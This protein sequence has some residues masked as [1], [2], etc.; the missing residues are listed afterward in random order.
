MKT[1]QLFSTF[2]LV[3]LTISVA[4]AKKSAGLVEKRR[5]IVKI[6]DV[7]ARDQLSVD[8]QYGQVKI[9]LWDRKEIRVDITITANAPTDQRAADYLSAIAIDEKREGHM[10]LLRTTI[11]R[12]S[13][14]SNS[15]NSWR[16]KPGE[17]NFIQI[18]YVVNMPKGNALIVRNKFGNTDIPTF[19]APLTV[20]SRYG[21]FSADDLENV[22]NS[23]EVLYGNAKIGRM[24]GGKLEVRYSNLDLDRV[25]TLSLINKFGKLTIGEVGSLDADIDYSGAIIGSIKESCRVKLSYSGGFQVDQLPRSAENVDIQ[26]AY[27]SVTLPAE[28][29]QFDI[30][31]THGS[32]RLPA[33]VKVQY[34]NQPD[35]NHTTR[36]YTGKLGAGSGTNIKVVS[37]FGDVR[38][39]D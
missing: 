10:I 27:S 1:I 8:N 2:F 34:T 25:R 23:I 37:R 7:D 36:Q 5:N 14:G 28:A 11:N 12:D 26:A 24:D 15:W 33:H 39:K 18:D 4:Q 31:V 20:F 19:Q 22:R 21:N 13:F 38:L 17:K 16:S 30:T 29:S 9:H 6:Y 3:C 35:N 32:F